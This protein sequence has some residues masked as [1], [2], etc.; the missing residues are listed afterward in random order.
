MCVVTVY[1]WIVV[2]VEMRWQR[3]IGK[4]CMY[5]GGGVCACVSTL[6]MVVGGLREGRPIGK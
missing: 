2:V 6:V 4:V 1:V 5:G 3:K